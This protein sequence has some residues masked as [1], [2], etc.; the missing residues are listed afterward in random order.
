MGKILPYIILALVNTLGVMALGS[1]L[2]KVPIR[3]DIGIILG[4]SALFLL[5]GLG[6]GLLISTVAN[7]QQE[8]MLAA[9]MTLLPGIFLSGFFFPVE[10]MPRVLQWISRAIPL[11]YYLIIIRSLMIKG[12]GIEAIRDEIFALIVF[13][14]T[15]LALAAMRLR[16]RL[17]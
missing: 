14:V 7:T 10:A 17:D 2:F 16:K 4:V 13:G 3:G 12:V 11:R 9:Y 15:I 5:S 8:A 6:T 1:W